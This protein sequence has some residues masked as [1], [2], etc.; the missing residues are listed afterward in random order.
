M[1]PQVAIVSPDP[2]LNSD[3]PEYFARHMRIMEKVM[4][5]WPMP[6][7]QKQ[8]D[9]VREAF[10]ADVRRPFVLKPSFPYGSPHPSGHP[11]PPAGGAHRYQQAMDRT[12]PLDQHLGTP[13]S[14][15]A[16]Y[17]SHPISPPVSAGPGDS[18]GDSP[19]AQSLVLMPHDGQAS[20]MRQ[21]MAIPNGQPSWN[22]ARIFECV[23][24]G[25]LMGAPPPFLARR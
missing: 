24:T 11:S 8:I 17:P 25:P 15:P 22:P 9:A 4:D 13:H 5:A 23:S 16:S 18:K 2:E 21:D 12:G 10:S 3:A 19:P 6:E 20:D 7:L 14:Q 1:L